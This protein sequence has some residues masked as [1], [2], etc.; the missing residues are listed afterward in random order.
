MDRGAVTSP[1]KRAHGTGARDQFRGCH[2]GGH[3]PFSGIRAHAKAVGARIRRIRRN[4]P[5]EGDRGGSV[6][7]VMPDAA[8]SGDPASMRPCARKYGPRIAAFGGVRGDERRNRRNEPVYSKISWNFNG[9]RVEGPF[10]KALKT[11]N[12]ADS[13]FVVTGRDPVT[14]RAAAPD[15]IAGSGPGNDKS[16]DGCGG[17]P[18]MFVVCS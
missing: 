10:A 3:S 13:F 7:F 15:W 17:L 8:R 6:L 18:C 1:A 4:E 11:N 16:G 2:L 5:M 12:F 9:L 14:Q